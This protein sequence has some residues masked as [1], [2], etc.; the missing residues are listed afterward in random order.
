MANNNSQ[1]VYVLTNPAMIGLVK[2]GKTNQ[3]DVDERMKQLYG[4]GVPFPFDCVFACQVKDA[5]EVEKALHFSFGNVRVNPNREFFR[6]EADRVIAILKLLEVKDITIEFEKQLEANLDDIDKQSSQ[7]IKNSKR[8]RMD[9]HEL[10]IPDGS[11]L[12]SK[13]GLVQIKVIGAKKVNLDGKEC[14]LTEATRKLL[15]LTDDY[16]IQGSP[17][18]TF[19][20]EIVKEIYEKFHSETE[21]A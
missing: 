4:S 5:T 10:G 21:D 19:N 7:N 3:S 8:P 11:I 20:G 16:K 13:D 15:K 17:Y 6:I 9:F 18:W 2:I 14:S 1:I 12:I